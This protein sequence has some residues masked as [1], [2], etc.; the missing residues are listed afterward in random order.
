MNPARLVALTMVLMTKTGL[1]EGQ[2]RGE[3]PDIPPAGVFDSVLKHDLTAYFALRD[4]GPI[5]VSYQLLRDGP[6][7]TGIAYPKYY[8]WVVVR[9]GKRL[10]GNALGMLA[11]ELQGF[12]HVNRRT[13]GPT[14]FSHLGL[15]RIRAASSYHFRAVN[16]MYG[17]AKGV[18]PTTETLVKKGPCGHLGA[19]SSFDVARDRRRSRRVALESHCRLA[20]AL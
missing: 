14:R 10:D 19:P 12:Q 7:I 16:G 20:Q 11:R 17:G 3:H 4:S 15:P 8:V 13:Q 9:S 6:T 1:A 2:A 18:N 5:S